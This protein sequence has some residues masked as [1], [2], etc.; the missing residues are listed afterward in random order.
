MD[1]ALAALPFCYVT[2]TGRRTGK[3]HRIEI[4][5]AA[6][7]DERDTIF[8]LAGGREQSDWVRNLVAEPA[9]IVEVGAERFHGRGRVIEGGLDDETA[10]RLVYEKYREDDDLEEWRNEALPVAIDLR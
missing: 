6:A 10:R 3:P 8:I 7:E 9:C 1:E 5:F 2:T 4:W